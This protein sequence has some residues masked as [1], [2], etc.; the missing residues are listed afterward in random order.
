MQQTAS[1]PWH[2]VPLDRIEPQSST[3]P[4][5]YTE[6]DSPQKTSCYRFCMK[7]ERP[8]HSKQRSKE[9]SKDIRTR[10]RDILRVA[11]LGAGI[12]AGA[13]DEERSRKMAIEAQAPHEETSDVFKPYPGWRRS[14]NIEDRRLDVTGGPSFSF[15]TSA[16][17]KPHDIDR[18]PSGLEIDAGASHVGKSPAEIMRERLFHQGKEMLKKEIDRKSAEKRK[19]MS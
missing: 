1:D 16:E 18:E 15:G 10:A 7:Q 8:G 11:A 9:R 5:L 4:F 14:A 17:S 2:Y 12:L 3:G 19:P 6:V 13:T